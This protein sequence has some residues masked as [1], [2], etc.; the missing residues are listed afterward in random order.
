MCSV[1]LSS[2]FGGQPS[3]HAD[4]YDAADHLVM[5]DLDSNPSQRRPQLNVAKRWLMYEKNFDSSQTHKSDRSEALLLDFIAIRSQ[6]L[7][8]FN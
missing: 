3:D 8:L 7:S 4:L 2:H 5:V 6:N 1:C